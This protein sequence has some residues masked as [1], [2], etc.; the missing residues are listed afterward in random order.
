VAVLLGLHGGEVRRNYDAILW[1][2]DAVADG[3]EQRKGSL[4]VTELTGR[5]S[6]IGGEQYR[7]TFERARSQTGT[8]Q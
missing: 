8:G 4:G 7:I 6:K 3:G 5:L 1:Q 2:R